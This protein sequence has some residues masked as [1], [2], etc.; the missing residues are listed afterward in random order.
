[1]ELVVP[2]KVDY[3][4]VVVENCKKHPTCEGVFFSEKA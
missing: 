1:M 4:N 2:V 3:T